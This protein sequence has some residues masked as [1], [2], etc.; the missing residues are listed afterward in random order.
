MKYR[1]RAKALGTEYYVLSKQERKI[2]HLIA[3]G[4]SNKEIARKLEIAPET[5][6]SHIKNIFIK[7]EVNDRA[8]AVAQALLK[9]YGTLI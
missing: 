5:V 4:K 8:H 2:V 1:V 6:K 9:L 7:L 3:Q